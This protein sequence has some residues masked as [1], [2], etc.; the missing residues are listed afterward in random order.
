MIRLYNFCFFGVD[1]ALGVFGIYTFVGE[2]QLGGLLFASAWTGWFWFAA[3]LALAH[4]TK[5]EINNIGEFVSA[6]NQPPVSGFHWLVGV[7]FGTIYCVYFERSRWTLAQVA[8]ATSM[9]SL[10][11]S[12]STP[13]FLRQTPNIRRNNS[14]I[15]G[16]RRRQ[17]SQRNLSTTST[18]EFSL[19][20]TQLALDAL[21][22]GIIF[23]G[24]SCR[25]DF[26]F[27]LVLLWDFAM[28]YGIRHTTSFGVH[29][30]KQFS[31][32]CCMAFRRWICQSKI[33]LTAGLAT[34]LLRLTCKNCITPLWL[35]LCCV[36]IVSWDTFK[37]IFL[38][39]RRLVFKHD[40]RRSVLRSWRGCLYRI[41]KYAWTEVNWFQSRV[42]LLQHFQAV[43]LH[44]N[45][46]ILD[47]LIRW[48]WFDFF[49]MITENTMLFF[50]HWVVV[51][52]VAGRVHG[53]YALIHR[54]GLYFA[55]NYW[56]EHLCWPKR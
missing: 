8:L 24:L 49:E 25:T 18:A 2:S 5:V 51:L 42:E 20:R 27:R 56:L 33:K 21:I 31:A 52:V 32:C 7:W 22:A 45:R 47:F 23:F 15:I 48:G 44:P 9:A 29:V 43:V 6:A 39:H 54:R 30:R 35:W 46:Y 1:R 55:N 14:T 41:I 34:Q 19:E 16:L 36:V 10:I 53:C 50:L 40:C 38:F 28:L 17:I 12:G 37:V 4:L 13:S 3:C 26:T 11:A